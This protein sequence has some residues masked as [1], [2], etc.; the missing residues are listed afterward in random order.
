LL[1]RAQAFGRTRHLQQDPTKFSDKVEDRQDIS[2][3]AIGHLPQQTKCDYPVPNHAPVWLC[4]EKIRARAR[5]QVQLGS[6]TRQQ[7]KKLA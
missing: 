6:T 7:R 4:A 5:L 2:T 3:Y 1:V